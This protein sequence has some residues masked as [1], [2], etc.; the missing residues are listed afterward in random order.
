[1]LFWS[2]VARFLFC[3]IYAREY[4]YGSS[5]IISSLFFVYCCVSK[6]MVRVSLIYIY[7]LLRYIRCCLSLLGQRGDTVRTYQF[8]VLCLLTLFINV[9]AGPSFTAGAGGPGGLRRSTSSSS[10][11]RRSSTSAFSLGTGSVRGPGSWTRGSAGDRSSTSTASSK[12]SGPSSGAG[13]L[14]ENAKLPVTVTAVTVGADAVGAAGAVAS[15]E[16]EGV[17]AVPKGGVD[18]RAILSPAQEHEEE[19]EEGEATPS[20]VV[21]PIKLADDMGGGEG[22]ENMDTA[23]AEAAA[24]GAVGCAGES[25]DGATAVSNPGREASFGTVSSAMF[26]SGCDDARWGR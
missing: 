23:A 2:L 19:D 11:G 6:R 14:D 16:T 13:S 10:S 25:G 5:N 7:I 12:V 21:T 9:Q 24:G 1:M 4:I 8:V 26:M 17:S 3:C 22:R 15:V 20:E 18:A